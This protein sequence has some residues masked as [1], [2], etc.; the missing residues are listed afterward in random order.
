MNFLERVLRLLG[1][2]AKLAYYLQR[3]L[4]HLL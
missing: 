1:E 2:A 3:I 4:Q